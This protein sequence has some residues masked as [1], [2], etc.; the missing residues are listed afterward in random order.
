MEPIGQ[1]RLRSI[2]TRSSPVTRAM[3]SMAL[4]DSPRTRVPDTWWNVANERGGAAGSGSSSQE[5]AG[6]NVS[7]TSPIALPASVACSY[8]VK[9]GWIGNRI[10]SVTPAAA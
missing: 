6:A 7:M 10:G 2:A 5:L 9:P 4:I 3:V 8:V 1:R